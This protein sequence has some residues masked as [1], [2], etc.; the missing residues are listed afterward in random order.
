MKAHILILV[1]LL[2]STANADCP[3]VS[4]LEIKL[5]DLTCQTVLYNVDKSLDGEFY[6]S[7]AVE[8]TELNGKISELRVID[9]SKSGYPAPV[10]YKLE[11]G[12]FH[13]FILKNAKNNMCTKI[14]RETLMVVTEYMCCDTI[15]HAGFCL[16][17]K[18][19]ITVAI[20]DEQS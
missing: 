9:N 6:R 2:A 15:P 12:S 10:P 5:S 16:L 7:E 1:C 13:S 4:E 3:Y 17:P 18:P 19:L 8:V 20:K 11:I 14:D